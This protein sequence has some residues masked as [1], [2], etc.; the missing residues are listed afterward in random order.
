[1]KRFLTPS[2]VAVTIACS[3]IVVS[4]PSGRADDSGSP[5][6][7]VR[8]PAGYRRW[9][10][11][12]VAQ[13]AN[14]GELRCVVGNPLSIS[15]Y[16][17]GKLPFPDGSILLKL[18]WKRIALP[19]VEGAFVSGSAT[20]VQIMVK[21]SKRYATTGGWGFGRFYRR[22]ARGRSAA[23]NLLPMPRV[24]CSGA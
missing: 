11:V 15:A 20:T 19:E 9:E 5:I 24:Q 2:L 21:D 22:Q 1:V 23:S 4:L 12:A 3:A 13:E 6:Y 14:L 16:E 10:L 8:I 18:A 17:K 7:G